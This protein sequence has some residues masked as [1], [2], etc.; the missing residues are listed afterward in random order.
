M[1]VFVELL[2]LVPGTYKLTIS[3]PGFTTLERA[4][5]TL[6]VNLPTTADVQ[7]QVAGSSQAVEVSETGAPMV[8]TTDATIGNVFDNKQIEQV[9]IEARNVV[10]LLSLQSGV[11]YLG[12]R[13][14]QDTDTRARRPSAPAT[15][16][17]TTTSAPG[18]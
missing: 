14:N 16:S 11:I 5:L 1:K 12:N 9:P 6:Q 10:E 8:N 2:Q 18:R 15:P 3:A 4:D 13:V 7:L 17:S